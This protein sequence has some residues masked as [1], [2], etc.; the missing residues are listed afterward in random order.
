MHSSSC[1]TQSCKA[2]VKGSPR[3]L[4]KPSFYDTLSDMFIEHQFNP[5]LH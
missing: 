3:W 5:G 2:D 1:Y 4:L